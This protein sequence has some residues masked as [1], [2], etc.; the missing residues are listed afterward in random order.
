MFYRKIFVI[1]EMYGRN[2][3]STVTLIGNNDPHSAEKR[4]II[5]DRNK[6][7]DTTASS[8]RVSE[9]VIASV[10]KFAVCDSDGVAGLYTK[11]KSGLPE[12]IRKSIIMDFSSD[13]PE[14]TVRINVVPNCKVIKVC[15]DVQQRVR[16]DVMSMTGIALSKIN[17]KVEGIARN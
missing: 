11:R 17:V 9:D 14:V 10:I 2:K 7:T 12:N 8:L 16:E 13:S 3:P 1:I 6:I 15:E 4:G 5:M